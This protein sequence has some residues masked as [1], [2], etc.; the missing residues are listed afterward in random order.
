MKIHLITLLVL[1]PFAEGSLASDQGR[2]APAPLSAEQAALRRGQ[3]CTVAF[4][5]KA[6]ARVTDITER[7]TRRPLELL[8]L[9]ACNGDELLTPTERSGI[10]VRIPAT[11]L[12]AFGAGSLEALARRFESKR[13]TVTGVVEVR[14]HPARHDGS[15]KPRPRPEITVH[16]PGSIQVHTKP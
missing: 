15:G 7:G 1:L 3:V 8:L 9:D 4:T 11:A 10:I 2:D 13:V 16:S 12:A 14:P 6:T 5:V